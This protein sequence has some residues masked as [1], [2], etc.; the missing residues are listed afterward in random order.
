MFSRESA[1]GLDIGDAAVKVMQISGRRIYTLRGFTEMPLPAGIVVQGEIKQ[2]LK[3]ADLIKTAVKT[4]GIRSE[5]VIGALP[6]S[7]TFLK[8]LSLPHETSVSWRQRAETELRRHIPYELSEVWW[9]AQIIEEQP[10]CTKILAGVAPKTLVQA[11]TDAIN[12][13]GLTAIQLDLEP[14]AIARAALPQNPPHGCLL[15][16]DLGAT[17]STLIFT[18]AKSA[19]TTADGRSAADDLTA[20]LAEALHIEKPEAE[21]MKKQFGLKEGPPLYQSVMENYTRNLAERIRSVLTMSL[22]HDYCPAITEILLTGGGAL[23]KGLPEALTKELTL[24]TRLVE[25]WIAKNHCRKKLPA[26]QAPQYTTA[27]G[28]A[29]SAAYYDHF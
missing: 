16:L 11:Y 14:L 18:T 3:L 15:I 6:E 13:A 19:L 12:A 21:K 24:P 29:I 27:C 17:K 1:F 23:L 25:P 28:L 10:T 22:K 2:P 9:D 26:A 7:K 8:I 5:Y 4:A 20:K